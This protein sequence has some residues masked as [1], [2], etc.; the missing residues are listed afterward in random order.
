M[1]ATGTL[2]SDV[3]SGL[4]ILSDGGAFVAAKVTEQPDE[5]PGCDDERDGTSGDVPREQ[6][7]W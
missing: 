7:C 4:R 2:G 6:S 3:A 5:Y 1:V